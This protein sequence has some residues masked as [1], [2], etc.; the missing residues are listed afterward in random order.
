[1]APL[2]PARSSKSI[3]IQICV[4]DPRVKYIIYLFTCVCAHTHH[5]LS[6]S[7]TLVTRSKLQVDSHMDMCQNV[8]MCIYIYIDQCIYMYIYKC[9]CVCIFEVL[10]ASSTLV[11]CSKLHADSHMDICVKM[12]VCVHIYIFV[13]NYECVCVRAFDVLSASGTLVTCWRLQ[14][15][16]TIQM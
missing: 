16:N 12:Y 5:V 6:A 9:A 7:G 10:S 8:Y 13:Y 3:A 15:D 2:Q 1:M 11:I 14:I 4:L